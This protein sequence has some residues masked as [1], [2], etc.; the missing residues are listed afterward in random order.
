MRVTFYE[1]EKGY[2]YFLILFL[3]LLSSISICL[4]PC[5]IDEYSSSYLL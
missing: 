5:V 4:K 3:N 2:K 1:I